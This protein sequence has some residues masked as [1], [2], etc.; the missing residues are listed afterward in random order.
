M[1]ALVTMRFLVPACL[2]LIVSLRGDRARDEIR[3]LCNQSATRSSFTPLP[4]IRLA[5]HNG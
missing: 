5:V 1:L 2:A 4:R 3:Q